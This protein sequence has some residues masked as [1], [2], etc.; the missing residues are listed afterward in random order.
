MESLRAS[1]HGT[2][3]AVRASDAAFASSTSLLVKNG[4]SAFLPS[5]S[6]ASKRV[7]P[8]EGDA[9]RSHSVLVAQSRGEDESFRVYVKSPAPSAQSPGYSASPSCGSTGDCGGRHSVQSCEGVASGCVGCST[10]LT[11]IRTPLRKAPRQNSL[12]R[13]PSRSNSCCKRAAA[14]EDE[15]SFSF[16]RCE[17]KPARLPPRTSLAP[18]ASA[19]SSCRLSPRQKPFSSL[20]NDY[21]TASPALTQSSARPRASLV[22]RRSEPSADAPEA[23]RAECGDWRL[24]LRAQRTLEAQSESRQTA[25]GD[26]LNRAKLHL[27]I[28]GLTE[29]RGDIQE[30]E[31]T[32]DDPPM[33]ASLSQTSTMCSSSSLA[34]SR[35]QTSLSSCC[36]CS[37]FSTYGSGLTSTASSPRLDDGVTPTLLLR[38]GCKALP[39]CSSCG[40]G[41]DSLTASPA[42]LFPAATPGNAA[43]W[44]C[45]CPSTAV[46]SPH[47]S[48]QRSEASSTASVRAGLLCPAD[49]HSVL[50]VDCSP[51]FSFADEQGEKPFRGDPMQQPLGVELEL[52]SQ[53]LLATAAAV[54]QGEE[55]EARE[56]AVDPAPAKSP[57]RLQL[58]IPARVSRPVSRQ[59]SPSLRGE[60]EAEGVPKVTLPGV[61]RERCGSAQSPESSLLSV[62]ASSPTASPCTAPAE[63]DA[64]VP[65]PC[66][67]VASVP[68][69][70]RRLPT[71][72]LP[73]LSDFST[74]SS[75]APL[76]ESSPQPGAPAGA[77]Q[78]AFLMLPDSLL[79]P[80]SVDYEGAEEV[81][82]AHRQAQLAIQ[83]A[84]AQAQT[85]ARQA[86]ARAAAIAAAQDAASIAARRSFLGYRKMYTEYPDLARNIHDDYDL[87]CAEPRGWASPAPQ[88]T[89]GRAEKRV[90]VEEEAPG[91]A[92]DEEEAATSLSVC[93]TQ[94]PEEASSDEDQPFASSL[95]RPAQAEFSK[96]TV[97]SLLMAQGASEG[98]FAAEQHSEETGAARKAAEEPQPR[99][100]AAHVLLGEGQF[101]KVIIAE[102][103]ATK[104]PLAVKM[105]DKRKLRGAVADEW[106]FRKEVE[107]HRRL[108]VHRNVATLCDVYEDR[109]TLYMVMELCDRANLLDMIVEEGP[110]DEDLARTIFF[111]ILA[112]VLHCHQ[113]NVVH[114]DLKPENILFA[115]QS[116]D[117]VTLCAACA[118]E[119]DSSVAAA[120]APGRVECGAKRSPRRDASVS[121]AEKSAAFPP[122]VFG[123]ETGDG[124]AADA[125]GR[126]RSAR[127][128]ACGAVCNKTEAQSEKKQSQRDFLRNAT[129]KLI[130]FGAA[131]ASARGQLRGTTCGTVHYLAP[132]VLMGNYYDG[133]AS[134]AWSLGVILYTM[135]AAAPPFNAHTDAQLTRQITRGD[136]RMS[137]PVWWRVSAEAKDLVSRLLAVNPQNRMRVEEIAHHLWVQ[138]V[139]PPGLP[140]CFLNN[141]HCLSSLASAAAAMPRSDLELLTSPVCACRPVASSLPPALC[142]ECG[143]LS[144]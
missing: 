85:V 112:A 80:W 1:C 37:D 55:A 44:S 41:R 78:G 136:Y 12:Q 39:A 9:E 129:V 18:L 16:T 2:L 24:P 110:F 22:Q 133:F 135:L 48:S 6:P 109:D 10:V 105:I 107:M 62:P 73:S 144:A 68:T 127:C 21:R 13:N 83:R 51:C 91:F 77:S 52:V 14:A 45:S 92:C 119:R 28:R 60:P 95:A 125:K 97:L 63:G 114:R 117:T 115:R 4:M 5:F 69:V 53:S 26:G 113:H 82:A 31:L 87:F 142:G 76:A 118:A 36:G 70:A 35:S 121:T 88:A 137:G 25:L 19:S 56:K 75:P 72:L 100:G 74:A 11:G 122:L 64:C 38:S 108:P 139:T 40:G 140:S 123:A 59:P 128:S 47:F 102:H 23:S 54:A 138:R 98:S 61:G 15:P 71:C 134:D 43:P 42:S 116:S 3:R 65:S 124:D 17:E 94:T 81:D 67:S 103:R 143:L 66:R 120:A 126:C 141:P 104:R 33:S 132:E 106:N 131:C 96:P 58:P 84:A 20:V 89:A 46:A 86:A 111:Q 34:S 27:P 79:F 7:R 99:Q 49:G 30:G 93:S 90:E 8:R 130:D 57:L 50:S 101:G 29:Q 32:A